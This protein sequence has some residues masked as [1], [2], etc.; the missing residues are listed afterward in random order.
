MEGLQVRGVGGEEVGA[1][2]IGVEEEDM[3]ATRGIWTIYHFQHRSL[4]MLYLSRRTFMLSIL[5]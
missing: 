1:I 2:R 5:Q 4:M 3:E